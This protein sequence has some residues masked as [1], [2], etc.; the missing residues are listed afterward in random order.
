[1]AKWVN[2]WAVCHAQENKSGTKWSKDKFE[3]CVK[4]IKK[5]NKK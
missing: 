2:P 3:R 4:D 5:E 1:M